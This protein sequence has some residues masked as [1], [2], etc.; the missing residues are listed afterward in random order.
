MSFFELSEDSSIGAYVQASRSA[1]AGDRKG[2][3]RFLKQA[4]AR[5]YDSPED[6]TIDQ[7]FASLYGDPE[8]EAI[9]NEIKA[10]YSLP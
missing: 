7:T 10:R 1:L 3:L 5:G 9:K 2:A 8:F 6:L 4:T